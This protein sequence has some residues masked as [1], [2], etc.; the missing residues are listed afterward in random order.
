MLGFGLALAVCLCLALR[1]V[2]R[3][4]DMHRILVF[5]MFGSDQGGFSFYVFGGLVWMAPRGSKLRL[6]RELRTCVLLPDF[7]SSGLDAHL[8]A[9]VR[10]C[11]SPLA[12]AARRASSSSIC[13]CLGVTF[14][15]GVVCVV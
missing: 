10:W 8:G 7:G 5:S 13:S 3:F 1:A 9:S 14:F 15:R 4:L 6:R 12:C 2:R 11:T